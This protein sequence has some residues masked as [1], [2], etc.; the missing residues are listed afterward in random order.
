MN[1]HI[2]KIYTLPHNFFFYKPNQ[3][4]LFQEYCKKVKIPE[5]VQSEKYYYNNIN[6]FENNNS[7]IEYC[8]KIII[9]ENDDNVS[10]NSDVIS[11]IDET[12]V[13]MKKY[14]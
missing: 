3:P 4:R 14:L 10:S 6:F 1:F 7:C 5:N 11:D 8:K 2:G 13:D 9:L 12:W